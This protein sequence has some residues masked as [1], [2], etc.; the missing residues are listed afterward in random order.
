MVDDGNDQDSQLSRNYP[1]MYIQ[2]HVLSQQTQQ[3]INQRV[4]S[5]SEVMSD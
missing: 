5:F 4:A 3:D 1:I 2:S